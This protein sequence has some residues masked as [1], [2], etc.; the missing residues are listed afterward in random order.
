MANVSRNISTTTRGDT[1]LE[2][3]RPIRTG[4]STT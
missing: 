4:A 1:V 3:R 2:K